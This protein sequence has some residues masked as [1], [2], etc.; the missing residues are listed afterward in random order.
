MQ[1]FDGK[2]WFLLTVIPW[3]CTCYCY[4]FYHEKCTYLYTNCNGKI[5]FVKK[6]LNL[7]WVFTD[8][9]HFL[10]IS[11]HKNCDNTATNLNSENARS[12]MVASLLGSMGMGTEEEES[13][14]WRV[15]AAGFHHV[16]ARSRLACVWNLRTVQFFNFPNF[17]S[18]RGKP[19]ITETTDT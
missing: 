14:I 17:F 5:L 1:R 15:W 10:L 16:T 3:N 12:R 7:L 6:Y 2:A 4:T 9:S 19:R 8:F 13:S 18:G 11:E